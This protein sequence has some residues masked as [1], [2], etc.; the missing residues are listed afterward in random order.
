MNNKRPLLD[1]E[2]AEDEKPNDENIKFFNIGVKHGKAQAMKNAHNDM[3]TY[4]D[5]EL[6][7]QGVTPLTN[8]QLKAADKWLLT[9]IQRGKNK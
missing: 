6:N 3:K 8:P 4:S 7:G 2:W 9:P 1:Q 5:A